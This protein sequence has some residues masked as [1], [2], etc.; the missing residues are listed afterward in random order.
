MKI[1]HVPP[2]IEKRS[3]NDRRNRITIVRCLFLCSLFISSLVADVEK[4]LSEVEHFHP[5]EYRDVKTEN[6]GRCG[7]VVTAAVASLD[8]RHSY[9]AILLWQI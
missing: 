1:L 3:T 5:N 7:D 8:H 9:S 4:A 6:Y 2:F